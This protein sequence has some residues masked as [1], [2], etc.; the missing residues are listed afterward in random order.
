[1]RTIWLSPTLYRLL[2]LG[3]LIAGFLMLATFG[4]D[5]MGRLSGLLLIAAG[6]LVWTLRLYARYAAAPDSKEAGRHAD[7]Q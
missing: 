6:I 2:P 7:E 5:A 4:G 1:M 3:Y